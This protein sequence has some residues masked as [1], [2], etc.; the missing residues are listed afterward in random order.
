[1]QWKNTE[2]PT[3]AGSDGT[4]ITGPDVVET[5]QLLDRDGNVVATYTKDVSGSYSFAPQG[6]IQGTHDSGTVELTETYAEEGSSHQTIWADLELDPEA[7]SD[8]GTDPKF[9]AAI[10]GNV[11]GADLTHDSNFIA[12]VIGAC[13]ITG[14]KGSDYP[15]AA[16]AGVLFDGVQADCI[17]LANLNGDD[18][19]GNLTNARAAFGV[20]VD[21]NVA[22][23][24]CNYGLSLYAAPNTNYGGTPL[25][26]VPLIA[27]IE[28]S[29]QQRF[30]ALATAITANVT[31][32]DAPIGSIGIT[33]HATGRGKLF[34]SDGTAW[35]FAVVA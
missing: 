18:N 34:M 27:D 9:L 10:M 23:S 7:G 16:V 6:S 11:L 8:T 19:S 14:T 24:G 15:V 1:M 17:V 30:I 31:L 35:Q 22:G 25:G 5:M 2:V 4:K 32:T 20:S 33:S 3:F 26:F 29:N 13:A 21:N 28:F 12:G